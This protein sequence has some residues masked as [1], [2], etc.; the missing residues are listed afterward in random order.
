V[1]K[2]M[3][4]VISPIEKHGGGTYWLRC[5]IGY[6]NKDDSLN[7]YIQSL[8]VNTGTHKELQLQVRLMTDEDFAPRN[9]ASNGNGN[10][11]T[12]AAFHLPHTNPTTESV[13]AD[14]VPF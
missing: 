4:K 11:A 14:G 7:L 8:P 5:G 9:G 3:F 6:R 1:Q 12:R 10:G 2:E 13:A